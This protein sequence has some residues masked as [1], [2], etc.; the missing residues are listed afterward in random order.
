MLNDPMDE[1]GLH[2]SSK[3]WLTG[4]FRIAGYLNNPNRYVYIAA[5]K[6]AYTRR[7]LN[8]CVYTIENYVDI[9]HRQIDGEKKFYAQAKIMVP[10]ISAEAFEHWLKEF[11]LHPYV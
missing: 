10:Y 9:P 2:E 7:P 6:D 5:N 3:V 1:G 8:Y 11:K 4:D